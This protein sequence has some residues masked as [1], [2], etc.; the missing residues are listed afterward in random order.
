MTRLA[1]LDGDRT[2][3]DPANWVAIPRAMLPRLAGRYDEA[4]PELK[5][6]ILTTAQLEHAGRQARKDMPKGGA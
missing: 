6:I 3:T 1:L 5:P 4:S 2:N